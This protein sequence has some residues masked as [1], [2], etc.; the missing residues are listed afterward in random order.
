M[1]AFRFFPLTSSPLPS[2]LA[3]HISSA[4]SRSSTGMCRLGEGLSGDLDGVLLMV[5]A[6]C[7]GVRSALF[8][9]FTS[10][11]RSY[12]RM[13]FSNLFVTIFT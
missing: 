6:S 9:P 13:L 10:E 2:T 7:V 3:L 11:L 1:F 8:I 4:V 5:T 12:L